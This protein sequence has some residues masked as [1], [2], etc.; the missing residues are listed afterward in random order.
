MATV[1]KETGDWHVLT[2]D[3]RELIV[4]NVD[5][6]HNNLNYVKNKFYLNFS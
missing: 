1:Y 3:G 5:D 6:P 2:T 4:S